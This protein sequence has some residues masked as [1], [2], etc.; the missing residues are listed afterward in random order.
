MGSPVGSILQGRWT[1]VSALDVCAEIANGTLEVVL[2]D[3]KLPNANPWA[4][5]PA[6]R[7]GQ[8]RVQ[9]DHDGRKG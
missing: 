6:G 7:A 5:S 2:K 1:C 9:L 4:L 8:I 3:W